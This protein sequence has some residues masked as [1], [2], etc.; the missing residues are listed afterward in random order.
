MRGGATG[1]QA[2]YGAAL[3]V[4]DIMLCSVIFGMQFKPLT[5][6]QVCPYLATS[7]MVD[8]NIKLKDWLV[9]FVASNAARFRRETDG[10]EIKGAVY[11]KIEKNGDVLV[12]KSILTEQFSTRGRVP[13]AFMRWCEKKGYLYTNH[14]PNNRHWEVWAT[15]PGIE[16]SSPVYWFRA[17][18]FANPDQSGTLVDIDLPFT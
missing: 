14:S 7:E 15:I 10:D 3:L 16:N 6:D 8:T 1:K 12:L 11:G 13:A 4:G 5:I 18:M 2:N 9:G 17:A